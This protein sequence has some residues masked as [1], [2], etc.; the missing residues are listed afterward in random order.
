MNE[1]VWDTSCD[2]ETLR[3]RALR[4]A[5]SSNPY[6]L[7][8]TIVANSVNWTADDIKWI[9]TPPQWHKCMG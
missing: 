8:S 9:I 1:I 6:A 5:I 7:E 4:I 2:L 3:Q